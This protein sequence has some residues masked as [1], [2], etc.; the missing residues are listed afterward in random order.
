MHIDNPTRVITLV[1]YPNTLLMK[2]LYIVR[3][4]KSSW[5]H[6]ELMDAERPLLEKGIKKTLRVTDFLRGKKLSVDIII[7][8]PAVRAYETAK[9]YSPIFTYD[10]ENVIINDKIYGHNTDSLFEILFEL[11]N[12][13]NSVMMVGH[14][15]TFTD[16]ANHFLDKQIDWLPTS[17][18]IRINF[19]TD[20][21]Q[22]ISLANKFVEFVVYPSMLK[23]A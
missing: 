11:D 4:A 15:P 22:E 10:P 1:G 12:N 21:W 17:G 13:F 16:F 7:S 14:N 6:P 5:E 9:L 19:H 2:T 20:K 3:H 18:V 23:K 8:S